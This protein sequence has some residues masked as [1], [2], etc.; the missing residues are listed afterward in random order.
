MKLPNTSQA[1]D[2]CYLDL[3]V[4]F[5]GQNICFSFRCL[6]R[7]FILMLRLAGVSSR[8]KTRVTQS[9]LFSN[10][11]CEGAAVVSLQEA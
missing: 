5:N 8:A 2:I 3:E 10:S 1:F 4:L 11:F 6:L 9:S 7:E